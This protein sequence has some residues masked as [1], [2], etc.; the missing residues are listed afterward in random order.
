MSIIKQ[1]QDTPDQR[2]GP[3]D[4]FVVQSEYSTWYVT[5]ATAEAV[6]RALDRR[7]LRPRWLRFVDLNGSRA[8][9]RADRV[10]AVF[11]STELQRTRD[12]ELGY[13]RRKE[14]RADRRWDDEEF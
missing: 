11:E 12:R 7:W 14:E 3:G 9:L 13:L 5:A 2:P 4:Y 1:K 6:G 10:E 8:W